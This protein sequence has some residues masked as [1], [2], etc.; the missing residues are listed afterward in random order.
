MSRGALICND[1]GKQMETQLMKLPGQLA[2]I[3]IGEGWQ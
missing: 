2:P 3:A 1:S